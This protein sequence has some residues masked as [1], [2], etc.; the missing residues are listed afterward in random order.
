MCRS[1][2]APGN[3]EARQLRA[4][5][6]TAQCSGQGSGNAIYVKLPAAPRALRQRLEPVPATLPTG[7]GLVWTMPACHEGRGAVAIGSGSASRAA[8]S[9]A[10]R[11]CASMRARLSGVSRLM[12]PMAP[13]R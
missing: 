11:A 10:I 4:R 13:S 8:I 12:R 6:D 1:A 5:L 3:A 9:F 7:S 2:S